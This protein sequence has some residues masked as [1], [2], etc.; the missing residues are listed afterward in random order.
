MLSS[1]PMLVLLV[2]ISE[3]VCE[4]RVQNVQRRSQHVVVMTLLF[5][6]KAKY[7]IHKD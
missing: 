7:R 2:S 6:R 1:L 5:S 3:F 4:T